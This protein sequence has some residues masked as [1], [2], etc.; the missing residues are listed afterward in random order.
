MR[1]SITAI[2]VT[3][4]TLAGC[5]GWP[6][7]ASLPRELAPL[8]F[9]LGE[10]DGGG[11]GAP[12]QAS[13]GTS[14][15]TSLQDRVIVRTNFAAIAAT[16]K[17][18]ASRHDDLMII[19]V[20]ERGAVRAD[21][22]DNE[23]HVIRYAVTVSGPGRAVFVSD[24][25]AGAPRYRLAYETAPDGVVKGS[26]SVAPPGKPDAFTPYLTWD[27]RRTDRSRSAA[28]RRPNHLDACPYMV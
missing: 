9:L 5:L 10:W 20:D 6:A 11:S 23:G 3:V 24:V 14:F 21:Y 1:P 4:A 28:H 17:T 22:Y 19:Y 27:M 15:A 18:P 26:F 16:D 2:A 13:G 8:G 7:A 25:P 12:G